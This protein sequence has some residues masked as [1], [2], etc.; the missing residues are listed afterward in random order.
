MEDEHEPEV[1]FSLDDYDTDI[2]TNQ[3]KG[4]PA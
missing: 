3:G 2:G 4:K 1:I